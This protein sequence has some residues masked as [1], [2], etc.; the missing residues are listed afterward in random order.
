MS[1]AV[2]IAA[3]LDRHLRA[4]RGEGGE[5]A[6]LRGADLRGA[7]LVGADLSHADLRGADLRGADL[8]SAR[9]FMARL[10]AAD[11]RGADLRGADLRMARFGHATLTDAT[12]T[13]AR[14]GG[15]Y[16]GDDIALVGA[17]MPDGRSWE[18]YREDHLAGIC[19]D[20]VVVAR[21][22]AAWGGHTWESCPMGAAFGIDKFEDVEDAGL[23]LRVGC[24]VALYD[25]GLL[26]PTGAVRA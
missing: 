12:L 7:D 8:T 5:I 2:D 17:A 11:L 10:E 24:W 23:R 26:T 15:G 19:S 1:R 18:E 21:A 25:A 14:F 13:G 20:P 6:D 3:V 22:L 4:L 16:P 9:L